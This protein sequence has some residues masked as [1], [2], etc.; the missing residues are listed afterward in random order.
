[1]EVTKMKPLFVCAFM[2]LSEINAEGTETTENEPSMAFYIPDHDLPL[3]GCDA[4]WLQA[5]R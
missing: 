3:P 4:H 2:A 5:R 1:M